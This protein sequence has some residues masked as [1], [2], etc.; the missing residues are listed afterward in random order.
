[1]PPP[2]PTSGNQLQLTQPAPILHVHAEPCLP[3]VR[4]ME[5][6]A[7][8]QHGRLQQPQLVLRQGNARLAAFPVH[9][10]RLVHTLANAS[11]ALVINPGQQL[12]RVALHRVISVQQVQCLA[13]HGTAQQA[14]DGGARASACTRNT[15]CSAGQVMD[16]KS[17]MKLRVAGGS[18]ELSNLL[19]RAP[20]KAGRC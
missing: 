19:S 12:T 7:V 18:A 11:N 15:L 3:G 6:C 17:F 5:G 1:M 16:E 4:G 2:K 8:V 9:A 13:L 20:S 14:L 10:S